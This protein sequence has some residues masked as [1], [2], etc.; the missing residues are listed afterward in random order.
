MAD[1]VMRGIVPPAGFE[2]R[3]TVPVLEAPT[4]SLENHGGP[5]LGSV[6]VVPV[7]WGAAWSDTANA[8]L[9]ADL[10]AFF[11]F[12]LTSEYMDL[13]AEYSTETTAIEH[14][15]RL[16]SVPIASSEPGTVVGGVR[17]VTDAQIHTALQEFVDDGTLPETTPDTLYFVYLPPGVVSLLDS[18]RSC[19]AGGFC[20]YH[21]HAGG[22]RYAVV[23]FVDCRG[24]VFPGALRDTLT[25]V[26]SHELAEAI[27]DA[28]LDAWWD[29]ATGEEV[30]D[31]CNRDTTRLGRFL[32][33]TEWSNVQN[34][35]VVAPA[36]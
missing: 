27:T 20:G 22:L 10:D 9:A 33:Q 30:G 35:C 5:L 26:S 25:V 32:V 8:Q 28:D 7:Y 31:I 18:S 19:A 34:A 29:D 36:G 15:Q 4:P 1:R 14:G 11:D 23:P 21:N 2:P 24:C 16:A 13:L 3:G 17:Q 12:I 6:E